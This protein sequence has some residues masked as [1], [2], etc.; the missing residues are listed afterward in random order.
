MN[1]K[2][3]FIDLDSKKYN[4]VLKRKKVNK[5]KVILPLFSYVSCELNTDGSEF[6]LKIFDRVA[7]YYLGNK[8]DIF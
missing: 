2:K 4:F 1:D 3:I 6:H 7:C 8:K 5:I